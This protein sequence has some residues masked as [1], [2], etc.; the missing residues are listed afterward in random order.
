M[1][2]SVRLEQK[3]NIFWGEGPIPLTQQSVQVSGGGLLS[4]TEAP[5]AQHGEHPLHVERVVLLK[6]LQLYG[7]DVQRQ[8]ADL[9]PRFPDGSSHGHQLLLLHYVGC[10]MRPRL[11]N[12]GLSGSELKALTAASPTGV[13][14]LFGRVLGYGSCLSL[15]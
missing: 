6:L 3:V 1:V 4:L 15:P 5:V 9:S 2:A 12:T 7:G 10:E 14:D 13:A 8:S 11:V